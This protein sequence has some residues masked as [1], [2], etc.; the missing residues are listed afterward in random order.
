MNH[1]ITLGVHKAATDA[2]VRVAYGR[3]A[4]T[5]HPDLFDN[6]PVKAAKMADLNVAYNIL[7]DA[8]RR[9]AYDVHLA[10]TNKPCSTCNGKGAV[11]KQKGFSKKT[12][13]ICGACRGGGV[14]L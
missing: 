5:L 6:E 10:V 2:E 8:K 13:A 4:L 14:V 1:Y 7:K 11:M 12:A 9:K 3:L